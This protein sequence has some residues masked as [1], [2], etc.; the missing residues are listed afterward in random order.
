MKKRQ[1]FLLF[2]MLNDFQTAVELVEEVHLC[3]N[4]AEKTTESSDSKDEKEAEPAWQE[5]LTEVILNLMS[6]DSHLA[7]VVASSVLSS[8]MPYLTIPA[9][10]QITEV[11][12]PKSGKED[13]AGGV[14]VEDKEDDESDDDDDD[15]DS[16]IDEDIAEVESEEEDDD[17]EESESEE[18]EEEQNEDMEVD[19]NFRTSI[20]D[21][22]GEA[23]VKEDDDDDEELSDLSDSEM[24]KLDDMLAEVFRQK[25]K[26]STKKKSLEERRKQLYTFRT[27]VMDLIEVLTKSDR[28][29]DFVLELLQPLLLNMKSDSPENKDVVNKS[30]T[31]LQQLKQKTHGLVDSLHTADEQKVFVTDLL[32]ISK[33]IADTSKL[34]DVALACHIAI[35]LSY[36]G[37]KVPGYQCNELIETSLMQII[38]KE[39][40]KPHPVFFSNLIE[41]NITRYQFLVPMLTS[42]LKDS[43]LKLHGKMICCSLLSTLLK[44]TQQECESTEQ[45]DLVKDAT[46]TVSE[47]ISTLQ[48]EDIKVMFTKELFSLSLVLLNRDDVFTECPFGTDLVTKISEIKSKLKTDTRKL[49]NKFIAGIQRR[50]SKAE[51]TSKAKRKLPNGDVEAP[52]SKKAKH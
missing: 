40:S 3:Y 7:R 19:E 43:T 35:K 13:D 11:L 33:N 6:L 31:I 51:K 25:K 29:G 17:E 14:M 9:I 21:A 23:A 27:R 48:A 26:A 2:F 28:C 42:S 16:L 12:I 8:I 47:L 18:S 24:F 49:A 38:S 5:V 39:K 44:K 52:S 10:N 46:S 22:L 15:D 36:D 4:K 45:K 37:D 50:N 41:H 1:N 34:R 32:D 30:R 20:K